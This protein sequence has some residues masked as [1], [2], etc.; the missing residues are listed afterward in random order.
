MGGKIQSKEELDAKA[1]VIIN[2]VAPKEASLP[3]E[4]ESD[5]LGW[6]EKSAERGS[7]QSQRLLADI[8][9]L[10]RKREEINGFEFAPEDYLRVARRVV[11]SIQED[12][13]DNGRMCPVCHRPNPLH[14]EV[15]LHTE[16]EHEASS[17]VE[18]LAIPDRPTGNSDSLT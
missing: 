6:I 15:R 1:D 12:Y 3:D 14:N 18:T 17:E 10:T 9:G 11:R 5:L 2:E 7:P 8:K 13:K 16:Q 4:G